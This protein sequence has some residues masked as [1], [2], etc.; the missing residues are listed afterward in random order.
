M[1]SQVI[2]SEKSPATT[3]RC[4]NDIILNNE[5]Q[6]EEGFSGGLAVKNPPVWR[7]CSRRCGFHPCLEWDG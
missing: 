1:C 3:R 7:R 4:P 5:M 6:N 2:I